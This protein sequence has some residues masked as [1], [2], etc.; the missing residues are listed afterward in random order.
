MLLWSQQMCTPSLCRPGENVLIIEES[1]PGET[2]EIVENEISLSSIHLAVRCFVSVNPVSQKIDNGV[3]IFWLQSFLPLTFFYELGHAKISFDDF[4]TRQPGN[5]SNKLFHYRK[6][7]IR[8]INGKV[9]NIEMYILLDHKNIAYL[10]N[11]DQSVV[12]PS[13]LYDVVPLG[14]LWNNDESFFSSLHYV[15]FLIPFVLTSLIEALYTFILLSSTTL[16]TKKKEEK[17]FL[18]L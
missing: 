8:R 12:Q 13:Y 7:P 18:L 10:L 1:F 4:L 17:Q 6:N 3:K 14:V 15:R 16:L 2:E 11:C 9:S 5:K